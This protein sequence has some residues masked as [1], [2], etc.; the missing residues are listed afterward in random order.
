M[1]KAPDDP[2]FSV[3]ALARSAIASPEKRSNSKKANNKTMKAMKNK[4]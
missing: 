3:L 1:S 2:R 4:A